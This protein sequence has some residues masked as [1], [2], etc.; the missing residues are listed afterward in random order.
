[1][2]VRLEYESSGKGTQHAVCGLSADFW[3]VKE[4]RISVLGAEL[5]MLHSVTIEPPAPSRGDSPQFCSEHVAIPTTEACRA[6]LI[7]IISGGCCVCLFTR[8]AQ[9]FLSGGHACVRVA[10]SQPSA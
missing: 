4:A 10:F 3:Q 2:Q 5:Q 9:S 6:I 1:M 7:D 8:L